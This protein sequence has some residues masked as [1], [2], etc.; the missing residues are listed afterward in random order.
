MFSVAGNLVRTPGDAWPCDVYVFCSAWQARDGFWRGFDDADRPRVASSFSLSLSTPSRPTV[1]I[2][3]VT[4]TTMKAYPS[5]TSVTRLASICTAAGAALSLVS[6]DVKQ[7][8]EAKAPT[9]QVSPGQMPKYD[10]D[11]AKVSVDSKPAEVTVPKVTTEQKTITVPDVNVTMPGE[12]P[13]PA[14]AASPVTSPT[15]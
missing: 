8:Q 15:P 1:A 5:L 9:V 10:V 3:I 14:A 11:T 4:I 12:S 7:T 2:R 13:S 6:C